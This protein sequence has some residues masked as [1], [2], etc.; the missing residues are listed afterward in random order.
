MYLF[1]YV[2]VYLCICLLIYMFTGIDP[3]ALLRWSIIRTLIRSVFA[4]SAAGDKYRNS[5]SKSN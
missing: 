1:T 3:V 5:D 4:F 2:Y